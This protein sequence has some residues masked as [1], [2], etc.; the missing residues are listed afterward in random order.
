[1]VLGLACLAVLVVAEAV[2][3]DPLFPVRLL[4]HPVPALFLGVAIVVSTVYSS[5]LAQQSVFH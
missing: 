3:H 1:V 4:A 2:Q 5:F